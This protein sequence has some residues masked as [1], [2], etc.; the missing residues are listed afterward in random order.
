MLVEQLFLKPHAARGQGGSLLVDL[1]EGFEDRSE[2][3][4]RC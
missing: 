4:L 2:I 1:R 3:T